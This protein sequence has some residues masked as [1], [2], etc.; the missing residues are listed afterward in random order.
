[1]EGT[2]SL[3][4]RASV[5]GRY[6]HCNVTLT[7][8]AGSGYN[9]RMN[10]S[11]VVAAAILVLL[12]T[13]GASVARAGHTLGTEWWFGAGVNSPDYNDGSIAVGRAGLGVTAWRTLAV[14]ANAQAD[15]DHWFGFGYAGVIAPAIGS[16][17]P[18]GRFHYGRRDDNN[19]D[20]SQWSAGVRY[21]VET[22][23]VYVEV[24]GIIRPGSGTGICL[25]ITF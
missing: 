6:G 13:A 7:R 3:R 5:L 16:L 23:K 12:F 20:Y 11:R 2:P 14:G 21:G 8:A 1:M 9:G 19:D 25:G 24:F 17:E 10:I 4:P 18:Y 22:L 15:R